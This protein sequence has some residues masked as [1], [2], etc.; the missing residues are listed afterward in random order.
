MKRKPSIS[1]I[2]VQI[3]KI[4]AD[5]CRLADAIAAENTPVK[6]GSGVYN[7]ACGT[8]AFKRKS[9]QLTRSQA[10]VLDALVDNR[11]TLITRDEMMVILYGEAGN[12]IITRS[13][14]QIICSIRRILGDESITTICGRGWILC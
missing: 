12:R 7:R 2:A 10:N 1:P 4:A 3:R 6:I 11:G 9:V 13:I 14:D 5:L 8:I